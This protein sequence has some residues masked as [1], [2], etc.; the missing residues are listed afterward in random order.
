MTTSDKKGVIFDLDGVLIDTGEFHR[1]SWHDLAEREGID[2]TDEFFYNTF[3][4]QNQQI[5]TKLFGRKLSDQET[6]RIAQHKE[7]R[8][9]DLIAGKLKLLEGARELVEDL[10]ANDFLLAIGTSAPKANLDFMLEHI[11]IH[12]YFD[13]YVT[14]EDVTNS[15]PA[16]DT[17]LKAAEKLSLSPAD[18]VVVEDAVPGVQAAKAGGMAVVAVTTTRAGNELTAADVIVDSLSE[19]NASD[20][21]KLLG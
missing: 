10:K 17:F 15:K 20:F 7:Q 11:P 16:P 18:C 14:C 9:R 8:Y 3:G 6:D 13:A 19:L 2:M 4:M 5:I 12:D 1:Q 21:E